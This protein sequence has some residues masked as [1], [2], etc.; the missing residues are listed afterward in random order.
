MTVTHPGPCYK[1]THGSIGGTKWGPLSKQ[2]HPAS[3]LAPWQPVLPG[4]L[5]RALPPAS[6]L[7][8]ATLTFPGF[9]FTLLSHGP[10]RSPTKSS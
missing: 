3:S 5:L 9:L 2:W 6:V 1:H 8:P 10:P 7:P 4:P